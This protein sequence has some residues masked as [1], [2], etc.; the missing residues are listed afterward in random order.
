MK[1]FLWPGVLAALAVQVGLSQ[2]AVENPAFN[3]VLIKPSAADAR[4]GGFNL[5]PGRLTAKNQSLKDLVRF[6]YGLHDYQLSGGLGWTDTERYEVIAT[7]P[8]ETTNAQRAK[9]LQAMLADRFGLTVHRESKEVSGYALVV[10]KNGHRLHVAESDQPEMMLGRSPA[11]GQRTLNAKRAKMSDLTSILADLLG[12]PVEDKTGLEGVFDFVMEWT[13][14]SVSE[15][16]LKPGAEKV[17]PAAEAQTGPSIF[18]A[19]QETLGLKLETKKVT[20]EAIAIDHAEK[21]SAN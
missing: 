16:S 1:R 3:A 8:G 4:G 7:F 15:R 18:T 6:A 19:L 12:K 17:E 2:P 14:D 9:L 13:P 11:S 5:S 10:G 21:P 20:V